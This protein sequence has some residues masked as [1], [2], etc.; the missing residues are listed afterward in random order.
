M[1]TKLLILFL[2]LSICPFLIAQKSL[3]EIINDKD[4]AWIAAYES[5][6]G[7]DMNID[8]ID[9]AIRKENYFI[10]NLQSGFY[11]SQDVYS[12]ETMSKNNILKF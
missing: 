9:S 3:D 2:T 8:L 7:F 1:K 4:V 6:L 11:R 12:D 5:Y 10:Q